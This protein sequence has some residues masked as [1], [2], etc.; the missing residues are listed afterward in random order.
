MSNTIFSDAWFRVSGL[1]VALLPSVQVQ[2]QFHRGRQWHVLQDTYT[3]RYFRASQQACNFILKLTLD[4]TVEEVWENFVNQH[5]EDAPSQEE[6]IQLLS[7][8]HLSNLLYSLEKADNEAIVARYKKHKKKELKGKLA[9]FLYLRVPLWNPNNWLNRVPTLVRLMTGWG[10]AV[11]WLSML[12]VGGLTMFENRQALADQ[13]QGALSLSNVPWLYVCLSALKLFHEAGH[14]FVCKRFGGEVRTFGVM[15][16]LLTPLPYVDASS[17]WGFANRWQRVYVS[18][19]G[20]AVE[21]FFA[22]AGAI[23]WAHTGPGLIN[24]LAFNVMLIGSI[25]SLLFNGNPLLRFDAYYMLSDYAE[26][27]NLYQKAQQ[28]WKYFG[29]RH[30]LGTVNAVSQ[31]TDKRE[32]LWLTIYGLLSFIYLMMVT[33]GISLYLM[34]QFLAL[35]LLVL[36]MTLFSRFLAPGYQLIKHLGSV[37]TQGNR[38]RG[39]ASTA[40]IALV[41][42]GILGFVPF[43]HGVRTSGV[44]QA[45]QSNSQY[46]QTAA[47]LVT[48]HVRHGDTVRKGQLIASLESED[49]QEEMRV[50]GYA[51][52]EAQMHFQQALYKAPHEVASIQKQLD[53]L[54]SRRS[55][56]LTLKKHLQLMADQDGEWVAPELHQM[57]GSWLQKG[58]LMG[59]IID[60]SHFRFLAIIQQEQADYLFKQDF[61][62][63]E[64]RLAGQSDIN[65]QID[66]VDLI[67][68]Q[69][70]KLPSVALG[71]MGGGDIPVSTTDATADKTLD[72][73]YTLYGDLPANAGGFTRLHGLSGTVRFALPPQPL[74][75]QAYRSLKQTAQKRYAL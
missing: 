33:L 8:L 12:L 31:A 61:L 24:S 54:F 34:D 41:L 23:I 38:R 29:N 9:A 63:T 19:A 65:I 11:V 7:Q 69:N 72:S 64:L 6:V 16:L 35:G 44:L 68:Y 1:R 42:V 50:N 58:H 2:T 18:F 53:F 60:R 47:R 5:P 55:E 15:F 73:F 75:V 59:E 3:Q 62:K 14:G 74:F 20:M 51:V 48:L 26:I 30:I 71:W 28:Q 40:G 32:W 17:S 49:L 27:P 36:A 21:F 22:A 39:V 52:A 45:N 37:Q 4:H 57:Q 43:P 56:L 67:P 25:S 13:T 46:L 70:Q 66:K 10:A